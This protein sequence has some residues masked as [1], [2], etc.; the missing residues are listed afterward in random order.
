[1]T[2]PNRSLYFGGTLVCDT[3][4]T[5]PGF[6]GG[7]PACPGAGVSSTT[8]SPTAD[9]RAAAAVTPRGI[10][11]PRSMSSRTTTLFPCSFTESILPTRRP[12]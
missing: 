3:G 1:M 5:V 10:F 4:M 11:T 2:A 12:R 6:I 9:L 7:A 8:G